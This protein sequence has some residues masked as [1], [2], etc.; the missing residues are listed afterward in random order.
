MN[1]NKVRMRGVGMVA[2]EEVGIKACGCCLL[3]LR[4][5]CVPACVTDG[6]LQSADRPSMLPG[7]QIIFGNLQTL[8]LK[9]AFISNCYKCSNTSTSAMKRIPSDCVSAWLCACAF[10]RVLCIGVVRCLFLRLC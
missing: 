9:G 3:L 2:E 8:L 5:A 6:E 1:P 10:M 7:C 4:Y